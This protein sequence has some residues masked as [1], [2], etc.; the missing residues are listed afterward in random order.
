[1]LEERVYSNLKYAIHVLLW[2]TL[3]SRS[4]VIH[5]VTHITY[6]KSTQ[7]GDY[8]KADTKLENSFFGMTLPKNLLDGVMTKLNLTKY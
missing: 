4:A 5:P 8:V 7:I 2:E 1:M 3:N 6:P